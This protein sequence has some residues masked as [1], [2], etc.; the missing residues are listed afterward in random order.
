MMQRDTKR[1]LIV[2]DDMEFVCDMQAHLSD[3][4]DFK[5]VGC[6]GTTHEALELVR[7]KLPHVIL[8]D[9]ILRNGN[10]G[11]DFIE[12]VEEMN[13]ELTIKPLIFVMSKNGFYESFSIKKG[14]PFI[15]KSPDIVPEVIMKRIARNFA[16]EFSCMHAPAPE[17]SPPRSIR[18]RAS[19]QME[20]K[21]D[22]LGAL[23]YK[24]SKYISYIVIYFAE[25]QGNH[26]NLDD[27]YELVAKKYNVTK[28]SVESAIRKAIQS[29]WDIAGDDAI[30]QYYGGFVESQKGA[31]TNLGFISHYVREIKRDY[32]S[33]YK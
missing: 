32:Y 10:D 20:S 25:M 19:D 29:I 27:A 1:I 33:E 4:E 11:T 8:A 6:A 24:G 3:R 23:K 7:D 15:E 14:L 30:K 12:A 21:L 13:H 2:D 26:P 16:P 5:Y 18:N 31:P 9:I 17:P 22:G 28:S